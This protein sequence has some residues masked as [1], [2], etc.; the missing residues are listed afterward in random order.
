[1]DPGQVVPVYG[2]D[3]RRDARRGGGSER[4]GADVGEVL[5]EAVP[6]ALPFLAKRFVVLHQQDL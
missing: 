3:L 6:V 1:M 2:Q 5:P 4:G